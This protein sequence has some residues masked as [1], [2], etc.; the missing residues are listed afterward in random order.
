MEEW[1]GEW[2]DGRKLESTRVPRVRRC[3]PVDD[4]EEDEDEEFGG[5][6]VK[7][8]VPRS[9]LVLETPIQS[10]GVDFMSERKGVLERLFKLTSIGQTVKGARVTGAAVG[11][12]DGG[13]FLDRLG[14]NGKRLAE[15]E[16]RKGKFTT[17]W[18]RE[19]EESC[20]RRR[21]KYLQRQ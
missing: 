16:N 15:I 14:Q 8:Y 20:L 1:I 21:D 9:G 7:R 18:T 4:E 10:R 13:S 12:N 5:S 11:D 6:L 2:P 19:E 17:Q 3:V